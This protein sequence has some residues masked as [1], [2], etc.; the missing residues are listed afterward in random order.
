MCVCFVLLA[1]CTARNVL[2]DK[3]G[4]SW[5]PKLGCN[6]LAG[7]ENTGV[8]CCRMVMVARDNRTAEVGV[9]GDVDTIL[10]GQDASVIL[11]VGETRMEFGREFAGECMEGVKDKGIGCRGGGKP[12]R[13]GG[14]YEVDKEGIREEGDI[15]I[16]GVQGG[17]MI[18]AA[19]EGIWSAKVF[20]WDVGKAEIKLGEV[21]KPAS[22]AAIEFLGLSEVGKVLMLSEYLD[23]GRGS[24]EIVSP[25]V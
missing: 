3:G 10:E 1:S 8:T 7:L 21:K 4:K 20:P 24:E 16:V 5:P 11:P 22:L 18:W 12:F 9:C 6:E 25:G 19:R 23:W 2:A 13:E 15:F 17:N 14:I